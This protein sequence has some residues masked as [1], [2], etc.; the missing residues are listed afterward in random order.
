MAKKVYIILEEDTD[1]TTNITGVYATKE[2]A[3][4]QLRKCYAERKFDY[5]D[6]WGDDDYEFLIDILYDNQY[7]LM[8]NEKFWSY[9]WIEEREIETKLDWEDD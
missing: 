6:M 2:L 3:Q 5:D 7:E 8:D 1:N 4:K 9:G